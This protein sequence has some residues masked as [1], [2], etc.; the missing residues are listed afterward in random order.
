MAV[1]VMVKEAFKLKSATGGIVGAIC[2]GVKRGTY[3][4][5]S[6]LGSATT[7]Y[8]AVESDNAI[9]PAGLGSMNPLFVGIMCLATGLMIVSS[10]IYMKPGMSDSGLVMV[11]N[12][13]SSVVPWFPYV[14]CVIITMISLSLCI[15]SAFNAQNV[16]QHYFGKKTNII[17]ILIQF[18]SVLFSAYAKSTDDV[19]MIADVLYMSIAIPNI[20]CLFLARRVIKDFYEANKVLLPGET[21]GL[22]VEKKKT[23]S[24]SSPL[25]SSEDRETTKKKLSAPPPEEEEDTEE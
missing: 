10:G 18:L 1:F 5:E 21:K 16:Y 3:S 20:A 11:K 22:V 13:F 23:K 4:N 8:A 14:L 6:G 25:S 17:Y 24:K 15:S 2:T 9:K 12:A 7:P 19:V